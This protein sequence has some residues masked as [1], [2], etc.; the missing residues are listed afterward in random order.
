M[1]DGD[2]PLLRAQEVKESLQGREL[3]LIEIVKKAYLTHADGD[4]VAPHSV[5]LRFPDASRNRVIALPAYLG[6]EFQV[7]GLKWI[8]SFPGNLDL[9]LER[10]S[11]V[12]IL[13]SLVTGQ[14]TAIM[15]GS[16]ISSIRTAASAALAAQS[17]CHGDPN[18]RLG[19]IGCGQINFQTV[20]FVSAGSPQINRLVIYDLSR[21]RAESF[22]DL[23]R[24]QFEE[25]EVE[26]ASNPGEV[27]RRCSLISIATTAV[28][29][30]IFDLSSCRPGSVILHLSLRDLS[31]QMILNGDNVVDDIDHVCREQTSIHLAEQLAGNRNFIRCTLADVLLG[32]SPPRV[33]PPGITIFSPFGLGILDLA[34]GSLALKLGLSQDIGIVVSDFLPESWTDKGGKLTKTPNS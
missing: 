2:I 5:F 30:H 6:G 4:S 29:P 21:S 14:P 10:A 18:P 25:M 15:E 33:D 11:A 32:K 23:C 27:L 16:I 9:G 34:V 13:N 26:V 28:S 20:R 3:E 7:A 19:I 31:P 12:L 24:R 1:N 22:K 8:S 17:L